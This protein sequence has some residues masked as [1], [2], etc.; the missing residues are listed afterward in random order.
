MQAR[1]TPGLPIQQLSTYASQD[2]AQS[3][4]QSLQASNLSSN[5][6]ALGG[7]AVSQPLPPLRVSTPSSSSTSNQMG[8]GHALYGHLVNSSMFPTST[9]NHGMIVAEG[10]PVLAQ[11]YQQQ[12]QKE[13]APNSFLSC[14]THLR[15]ETFNGRS[16]DPPPPGTYNPFPMES[17]ESKQRQQQ[18]QQQ[19]Q[20]QQQT[21]H[22]NEKVIPLP[23]LPPEAFRIA[24]ATAAQ[25]KQPVDCEQIKETSME[26]KVDMFN[27]ILNNDGEDE[28]DEEESDNDE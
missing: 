21:F 18:R 10:V 28:D 17:N 4:A 23:P 14:N 20:Q 13:T 2:H 26:K 22:S 16:R 15:L 9:H 24:A 1:G 6:W 7:V 12:L 25:E 3:P 5:Q 8:G 11:T 27:A 19:Q